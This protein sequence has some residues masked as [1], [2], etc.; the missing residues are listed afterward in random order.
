MVA[1]ITTSDK[2][3]NFKNMI[4]SFDV[5]ISPTDIYRA[6]YP[7]YY[8]GWLFGVAPYAFIKQ[9]GKVVVE[10]GIVAKIRSLIQ[11]ILFVAAVGWNVYQRPFPFSN[12]DISIKLEY[13]QVGKCIYEKFQ[14][15]F[16]LFLEIWIP[17]F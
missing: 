2:L 12:S 13:L 4:K 9:S 11:I 5:V 6:I 14:A 3:K 16:M 1:T 10:T 7:L 8:I 15:N 17:K